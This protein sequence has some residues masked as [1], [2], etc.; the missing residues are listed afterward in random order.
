[1]RPAQ[2]V[3]LV[4]HVG[5][6]VDL[7]DGHFGRVV[8]LARHQAVG[9]RMFSAEGQHELIAQRP[10]VLLN[11][12]EALLQITVNTHGRENMQP[13]RRSELHKCFFI[14]GIDLHAGIHD[15]ARTAAGAL[16]VANGLFRGHG[17]DQNVRLVPSWRRDA[18]ELV[19]V[20]WRHDIAISGY[21]MWPVKGTAAMRAKRQLAMVGI[22]R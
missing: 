3:E 16:A 9:H 20:E 4:G 6:G 21:P 19:G 5:M 1:M 8:H 2:A 14:E 7:H 15:G 17:Q 18:E 11:A 13:R 12:F 22:I 10:N